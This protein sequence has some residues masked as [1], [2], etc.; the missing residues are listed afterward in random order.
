MHARD[1][2]DSQIFASTKTKKSRRLN[3]APIR[4]EQ[5]QTSREQVGAWRNSR[6]SEHQQARRKALV[7]QLLECHNDPAYDGEKPSV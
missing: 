3:A 4:P 2:P 5:T 6:Q 7:T 1:H